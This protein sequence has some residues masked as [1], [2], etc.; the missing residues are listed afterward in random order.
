MSQELIDYRY[1]ARELQIESI[2]EQTD[3]ASDAEA[4]LLQPQLTT[5]LQV[6]HTPQFLL[7]SILERFFKDSAQQSQILETAIAFQVRINFLRNL[8]HHLEVAAINHS[9]QTL[10]LD[11]D[12]TFSHLLPPYGL[13]LPS[14]DHLPELIST[15]TQI[16]SDQLLEAIGTQTPLLRPRRD[17][18]FLMHTAQ[19]T[20]VPGEQMVTIPSAVEGVGLKLVFPPNQ[21]FAKRFLYIHSLD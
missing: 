9:T 14:S 17:I 21:N 1:H 16:A 15:A 2:I 6:M 20:L 5:L 8:L 18:A 4:Q 11:S 10:H 7:P 13:I 19:P 12:L 3:A